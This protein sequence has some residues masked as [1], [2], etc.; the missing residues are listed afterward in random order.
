MLQAHESLS[1]LGWTFFTSS[2]ENKQLKP[3]I[4][5]WENSASLDPT[6]VTEVLGDA[7]SHHVAEVGPDI[8]GWP[9]TRP[10]LFGIAV[11]RQSCMFTGSVQEFQSWFLRKVQL[12][13]DVFFQGPEE[14]ITQMMQELA[15]ARGHG[16]V[17]SPSFNMAFNPSCLVTLQEYA[18]LRSSR[19]GV[20]T[21]AFLCDLEQKPAF[22]ASGPF[23]PSCPTHSAIYSFAKKRVMT[24]QELL[25]AMSTLAAFGLPTSGIHVAY[26]L[27]LQHPHH[28]Y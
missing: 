17:D 11:L 26:L 16:R 10:R 25:G 4:L 28:L 14:D 27:C 1:H 6:V 18:N 7:Y 3:D 20:Q 23:L 15:A 2:E 21:G 9:Q 8:L 5:F 12:D 22:A 24:G 13:G 19:A